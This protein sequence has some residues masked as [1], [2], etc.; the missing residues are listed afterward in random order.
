MSYPSEYAFSCSPL[1]ELVYATMYS[2]PLSLYTVNRGVEKGTAPGIVRSQAH[3]SRHRTPELTHH[4]V[5]IITR[6]LA[7][8]V[9]GLAHGCVVLPEGVHGA[10][11][12]VLFA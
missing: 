3:R 9:T 11:A 1:V 6:P 5:P 10:Q 7:V 8:V 4:Y 2:F 12:R